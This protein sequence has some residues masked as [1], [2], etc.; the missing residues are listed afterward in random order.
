MDLIVLVVVLNEIV[1]CHNMY[2][3]RMASKLKAERREPSGENRSEI[4]NIPTTTGVLAC[5]R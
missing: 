3:C 5:F 2:S 4:K 1:L